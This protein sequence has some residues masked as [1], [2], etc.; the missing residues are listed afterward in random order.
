MGHC[1]TD[2][3]WATSPLLRRVMS[4]PTCSVEDAAELLGIGRSTAYAA[5]REGT[6]PARRLGRRLVVPTAPLLEM[7]GLQTTLRTDGVLDFHVSEFP[8]G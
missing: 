6:I 1:D 8:E 4:R 3:R 5:A 7:L 2:R